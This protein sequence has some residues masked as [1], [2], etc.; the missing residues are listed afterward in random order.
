MNW[1]EEKQTGGADDVATSFFPNQIPLPKKQA[2]G[3][4]EKTTLT[5]FNNH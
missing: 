2:M 5:G 4:L 3:R 1:D